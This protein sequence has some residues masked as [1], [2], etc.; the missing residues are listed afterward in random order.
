[1]KEETFDVRGMHCAS[2]SFVISEKI[3]TLPGVKSI[4][5][6][7]ASE[8]AIVSYDPEIITLDNMN[9]EINKL[10]YSLLS[11][12]NKKA[13][14]EK[15][16]DKITEL[17]QMRTMVI[18]VIP[19]SIIFFLIMIWMLIAKSV[20]FFP[21]FPISMELF[22]ILGFIFATP[23]L[24]WI[25]KPFIKGVWRFLRFRI[26]NM[27]TL[28]G[29]G[30][31]TAYIYSSI[32][33]FIPQV[34]DFLGNET[35]T[36]F[37]VTIIVIGFITLGKYLEARSKLKTGEALEKLIGL[38]AKTALVEKDGMERNIPIEEINLNDIIIVKPG[39]KI[40]VDGEIIEGNSSIDESMITGEP[41]PVDK[42]IGDKIIGATF[43][44]QGSFKLRATQIGS[45]TM[46]SQIIKMVEN[47]Q[48]SRAPIQ[49]LADKISSIFVP[50]VL[51]LSVVVL[52]L[53]A[54]VGSIFMPIN[55]A[56]SLGLISFVGIMVIACPCALGLATPTGIIVGTGKGAQN[57]ILIKDAESLEKFHKVN[58]IV[59]DKTGTITKGKPEVTDITLVK[60]EEF[61][62]KNETELLQILASLENKSEHPLAN[63]IVKKAQESQIEFLNV[64]NFEAI[65]GKGLKGEVG[66]ITFYAGNL[67]LASD[68][69]LNIDMNIINEFT[70]KGR[71]PVI[72]S[73]DKE[74]LAYIGIA[75]T[76]K[77][78]SIEVIKDLH[79]LGLKVAMITGDHANTA[80]YIAK[81]VGIDKVI[82]E[83]LP[84]DKAN[85]IKKL[86][87]AG[88]IVAMV[89]DGIND[90]P[91]LATAD[92][93]IAMGTGTEVAIESAGITL[94]GGNISKLPKAIKLSKKTMKIIKQNLFWAF[95][96]NIIGIPIAAGIL[97]PF[98]GIM[99]N[100]AIAGA[101]MA[102]SSVSVVSNALRLKTLKL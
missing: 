69:N 19:I 28:V 18:F 76:I 97:F 52:I 45:Q 68:L 94:L 87:S 95:I 17:N 51:I 62:I 101:A 2:C 100:P 4:N 23:I 98:F 37:D 44:K 48:G 75:D 25:G 58:F 8:K 86:Q 79:K 66:E 56:L 36:F 63:A 49:K 77:E 30:T 89:G 29:L 70:L 72:F 3:K 82:A 41:I 71:T 60:N 10:G 13:G 1:M 80:N 78:N 90:A 12:K 102:F 7:L 91:A 54:F 6:N 81:Q 46:L 5:V 33:L 83:V 47:A 21:Q 11:I 24:F 16:Q 43:N 39:Q 93:G 27:D 42:S 85:E 96:Y 57:G 35:G 99:L 84:Q 40:P 88:N 32:L 92:I 22:D 20:S 59:M 50:I 26:A 74:I 73:T 38:Q 53:W 9:Q 14:Q 65:E 67:K 55:E 61:K 31:L 34:K 64:E 15:Q